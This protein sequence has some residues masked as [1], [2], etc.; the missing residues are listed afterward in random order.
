MGSRM[1]DTQILAHRFMHV[2]LHVYLS[3]R[4]RVLRTI[5]ENLARRSKSY[6][7]VQDMNMEIHSYRQAVST[8][9]MSRQHRM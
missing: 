8:S 4:M 3:H 5:P 6:E 2:Y 7:L 9:T 1:G